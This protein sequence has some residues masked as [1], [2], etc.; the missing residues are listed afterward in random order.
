MSTFVLV[1]GAWQTASTWDVVVPQLLESGHTVVVPQLT[2]LENDEVALSPA[3]TLRTHIDDVIEVLTREN[4]DHVILVGHSY[5]GMIITGVAEEVPHR[6][7]HL[8]YVDAFIPDHGQSVLD[9][10]P[11]PVVEMFRQ[12]ADRSGDGWRLRA[13]EA[14]LDLWGLKPGAERDFVRSCLSDFSLRCFEEAI[15]LPANAAAKV[16][17]TFVACTADEYPARPVFQRFSDRA[18]SEGWTYYELPTGHDCHVE[19]PDTFVSKLLAL[20]ARPALIP[21]S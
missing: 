9:L 16:H 8:V 4:L 11:V 2:G 13:G 10:L 17:R 7:D 3:I 1:H 19:L 12:A 15:T 21:L 20:S 5:A 6:L 14:Q 18:R